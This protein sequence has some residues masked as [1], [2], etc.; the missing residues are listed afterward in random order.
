MNT[1]NEITIT[2]SVEQLYLMNILISQSNKYILSHLKTNNT[3]V[4]QSENFQSKFTAEPLI[5]DSGVHSTE[6]NSKCFDQENSTISLVDNKINPQS[7]IAF[8]TKK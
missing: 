5:Y 4:I 6:D 7:N 1:L 3:H 2:L 8:F